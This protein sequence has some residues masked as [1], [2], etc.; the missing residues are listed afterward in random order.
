MRA[1]KALSRLCK[2]SV[3]GVGGVWLL[4]VEAV[5]AGQPYEGSAGQVVKWVVSS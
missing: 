1:A 4:G 2:R 5:S 3:C